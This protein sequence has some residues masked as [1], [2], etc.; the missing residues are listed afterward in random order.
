MLF[1]DLVEAHVLSA[2]RRQ[3][4]VKLDV[5]RGGQA[6]P[7]TDPKGLHPLAV[8]QRRFATD[9]VNLFLEEVDRP[10]TP[11]RPRTASSPLHY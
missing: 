10:S 4:V 3:P 5:I 2:L 8:A 7:L 9:G 1:I 6:D 11:K